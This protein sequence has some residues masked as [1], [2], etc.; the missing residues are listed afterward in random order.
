MEFNKKHI[1]TLF[2]EKI[3][4][5]I[6]E[7]DNQW[8]EAAIENDPELHSMWEKLR[9][10]MDTPRG[11]QFLAG[12]D[13]DKEW[14]KVEG[15]LRRPE[16]HR[17]VFWTRARW[18]AVAAVLLI[19]ILI[20][21]TYEWR[22]GHAGRVT[23]ETARNTLLLK[24]ADGKEIALP[25]EG[26][27][28]VE[29]GGITVA[30]AAK[31]LSYTHK[32]EGPVQWATL[33]I[34][35]KLDYK[36]VLPDSTE[37]WLNSLSAL[38]FP[39]RFGDSK[40]EVYLEGEAF[41]KVAK[42]A[43]RPFIVHLARTDILVLGTDFNID[44]YDSNKI[45]TSLVRGSVAAQAGNRQLILQPGKEAVCENG[46]LSTNTFDPAETL[47]WIDGVHY[48]HNTSLGDIAR[49][50]LRW[51]DVAVVFD[52]AKLANEPFSG[53]IDKNK[54]LQVFLNNISTSS[55]VT[56]YFQQGTLHFK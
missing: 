15:R 44:A 42:E 9:Q 12:I 18:M 46:L 55:N 4:G 41:F 33:M 22:A 54:P 28:N 10:E 14:E 52:D 1:H 53:A 35:S 49:V 11:R 51:F 56:S 23:A 16:T 3:A 20:P 26:R 37:V 45:V 29:G 19:G 27:H 31:S 40:R 47:A 21:A 34:P 30:T 2:V 17:R 24:L 48:F 32:G 39:Y 13:A 7:A 38:R 5:T 8:V 43:N 50:L 6:S 25:T 36:V